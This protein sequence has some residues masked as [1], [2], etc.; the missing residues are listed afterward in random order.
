MY[1]SNVTFLFIPVFVLT[2]FYCL[3][4]SGHAWTVYFLSYAFGG[5]VILM[6]LVAPIQIH[7]TQWSALEP[8]LTPLDP[9]GPGLAPEVA[10]YQANV[11][12]E[13]SLLGFQV[14]RS[15][16]VKN[17]NPNSSASSTLF[18]NGATSEVAKILVVVATAGPVRTVT[19]LIAFST[20]FA[21]GTEVV[22]SNSPVISPFPSKRPPYHGFAFPDIRD[23]RRLLEIHRALVRRFQAGRIRID[24]VSADPDEY[25]RSR[26]FRLPMA[27]HVD[28]G[29]YYRDELAGVQ[30][31]TL[32]GA[33]LMSWRLLWP[34]KPIRAALRR[35]KAQRLLRELESESM[36]SV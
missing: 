14:L 25:Y 1:K 15:Y 5:W 22:T 23:A 34:V 4:A 36:G 2:A 21:D 19:G 13:L 8:E 3:I 32:K 7:Q 6:Y 12:A 27:R 28:L 35:S 33:Y 9:G 29:Y 26:D 10:E 11:L 31:P 30:R 18:W 17:L 16:A 20:E 24:P